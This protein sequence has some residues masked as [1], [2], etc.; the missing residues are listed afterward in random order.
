VRERFV[1]SALLRLQHAKALLGALL[2]GAGSLAFLL[3]VRSLALGLRSLE[4]D[5]GHMLLRAL[6]IPLD[7]REAPL[8]L[9]K[10]ALLFPDGRFQASALLKPCLDGAFAFLALLLPLLELLRQLLAA[11]AQL[12][13]LALHPQDPDR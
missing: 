7:L 12:T 11:S 9:E 13:N 6:Q 8:R 10:G 5:H 4:L 2:L 1:L 3:Q